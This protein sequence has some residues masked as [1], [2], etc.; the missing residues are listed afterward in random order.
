M[1]GDISVIIPNAQDKKDKELSD[2]KELCG[3]Y[4]E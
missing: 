2:V 3:Y 1:D 4:F